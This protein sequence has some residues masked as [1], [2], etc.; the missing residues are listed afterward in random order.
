MVIHKADPL[1]QIGPDIVPQ[2]PAE[3][4]HAGVGD[5][6][7]HLLRVQGI[8]VIVLHKDMAV[9]VA[10]HTDHP[11]GLQKS[12]DAERLQ[13]FQPMDGLVQPFGRNVIQIAEQLGFGALQGEQGPSIY[14]TAQH[15]YSPSGSAMAR[16][17]AKT[18]PPLPSFTGWLS[19]T[20][21]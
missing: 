17:T 6:M 19:L 9:P 4:Q 5:L 14:R 3:L 16:I 8:T 2:L 13:G 1:F 10:D 12:L 21:V 18:P 20:R 15:P 7:E 11:H